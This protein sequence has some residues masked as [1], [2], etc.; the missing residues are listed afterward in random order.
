M[1][2]PSSEL[3]S[4]VVDIVYAVLHALTNL[5]WPLSPIA[6]SFVQLSRRASHILS[7]PTP[8]SWFAVVVAGLTNTALAKSPCLDQSPVDAGH[9]AALHGSDGM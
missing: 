2:S 3:S 4:A 1:Y 7:S 8:E 6:E 9:K 5:L